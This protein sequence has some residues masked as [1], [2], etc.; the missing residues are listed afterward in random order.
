MNDAVIKKNGN[1]FYLKAKVAVDRIW[2]ID[3]G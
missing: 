1:T 2:I 3:E